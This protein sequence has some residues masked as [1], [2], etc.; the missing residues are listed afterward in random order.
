[1]YNNSVVLV[2]AT[3]RIIAEIQRREKERMFAFNLT[4]R[5]SVIASLLVFWSI[6]TAQITKLTRRI[7]TF[8]LNQN[9]LKYFVCFMGYRQWAHV[10][11]IM[12]MK[13]H[14]RKKTVS[15]HLQCRLYLDHILTIVCVVSSPCFLVSFVVVDMLSSQLFFSHSNQFWMNIFPTLWLCRLVDVIPFVSWNSVIKIFW[16]HNFVHSKN[17]SHRIDQSIYLFINVTFK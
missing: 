12:R 15:K 17:T 10:E 6:R 14:S 1:M 4:I 13:R 2:R 5:L 8:G 3:T 9:V 16:H 7:H 11:I